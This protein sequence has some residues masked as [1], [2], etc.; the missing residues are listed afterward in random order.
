MSIIVDKEFKNLIPP[1]SAEEYTQLERNIL[2]DGIRDALIVWR[3]SPTDYTIIDGHNRFQIAAAHHGIN[4]KVK[5][6]DFADRDEAK[7][8]IIRNQLGRRNLQLIDKVTLEDRKRSIL[9]EQAAKRNTGRPKKG[10][11]KSCPVSRQEKRENST[12]YKIAKAAG[13]SEDTV[14]KVRAI[15]ESSDEKLKEQVRSG[16][17]SINQAYRAVKG[18]EDKSPAQ[19]NKDFLQNIKDNHKKVKE[20]KTVNFT[21][22]VSDK[23]DQK[24]MAMDTYARLLRMGNG[25]EEVYMEIAEGELDLEWAA[26]GMI[27]SEKDNLIMSIAMWV[28]QL[29]TITEV[30]NA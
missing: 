10:D 27:Q 24:Y 22:V 26:K 13:T 25:I 8:W 5:E 3:T 28:M 18:I 11:K 9:A 15:N 17:V 29:K 14:R 23:E 7:L 6:M 20:G 12:D 2:K 16:D 4:F 19:I 30:L 1:L 21:A